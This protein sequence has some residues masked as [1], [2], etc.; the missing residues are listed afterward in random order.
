MTTS[1]LRLLALAVL[2]GVLAAC[3]A[4]SSEP[5]DAATDGAPGPVVVATTTI[6]GD[7]VGQ[8]VGEE[9]TV[10]V[11]MAPGQDPHGFAPS[12]Q[13]AERLREADLVVANGLGLE[14]AARDVLEA[15]EAD[16]VPVV[17]VAEAVDPLAPA[18]SAAEHE[19]HAD[20]E[21]AHEEGDPHVWFDPL[22]MAE[23][24]RVV[25]GALT[26][27]AEGDWAA[28]AEEVA[29][30]LEDT[31]EQVAEILAGV[32]DACRR[33][34]T[35]HDTLRYLAARY[36]FEVIGTVI[37]GTSTAAQPAARDFAALAE[38][39]R[40]TGAPAIFAETTQATRL[41]EALAE[42]VG[43]DIEIVE[44]YTG[45]LGEPGSGADTY[46]GMLTTDAQRIADALA[47]C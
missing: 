20:E 32:P 40:E 19:E 5:E 31:H 6:L 37:P 26:D 47:D 1:P 46:A 38:V 14:E 21:H 17:H 28:R 27:V 36:D 3:G 4:S 43:R 16:G 8:I 10:E 45:S 12:A 2:A 41:A 13:Q 25:G 9:G 30:D 35:N 42:E 39:L 18:E 44:L 22:R 11:L 33:L 7:M 23:G 15:A 24:A 34:V 29:A